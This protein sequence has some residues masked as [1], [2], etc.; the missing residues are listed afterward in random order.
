VYQ[1]V[2]RCDPPLPIE[3]FEREDVVRGVF[4]GEPVDGRSRV[5]E[6]EAEDGTGN[7]GVSATIDVT[8]D[9]AALQLPGAD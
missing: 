4:A 8:V 1:P 2:L 3:F 9:N 5:A 6:V 7:I